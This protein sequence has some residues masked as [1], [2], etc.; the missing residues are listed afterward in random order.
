MSGFVGFSEVVWVRSWSYKGHRIKAVMVVVLGRERL[1][2]SISFCFWVFNVLGGGFKWELLVV[3][4]L[5]LGR[6]LFGGIG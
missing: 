1:A 4:W 6:R 3:M 5:S 2:F